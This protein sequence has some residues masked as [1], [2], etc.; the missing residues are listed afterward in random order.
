MRA[1]RN[2]VARWGTK[3]TG[4]ELN[5]HIIAQDIEKIKRFLLYIGKKGG[6][7]GGKDC[8]DDSRGGHSG[9]GG[10]GRPGLRG[11]CQ[12]RKRYG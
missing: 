4:L 1:K 2:P 7:Y 5:T 11:V 10:P 6:S 9:F 8:F 3:T 12:G